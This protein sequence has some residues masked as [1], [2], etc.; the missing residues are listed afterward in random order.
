MTT[1][2]IP[3]A[4]IQEEALGDLKRRV[5]V[6][7]P[8]TGNRFLRLVYVTGQPGGKGKVHT[9][10]GE[11]VIFT[12]QGKA[13]VT[14]EGECFALEANTAFIVPPGKEHPLEVV[15]DVTWI[16]VSSFCDDCPLMK[17]SQA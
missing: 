6:T 9:H 5:V 10:P 4:S 13:A 1:G 7:P 3:V 12:I 8:R 2:P 16:A 11:E 17:A 15:G 14:I